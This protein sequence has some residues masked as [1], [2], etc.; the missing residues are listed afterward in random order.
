MYFV[1]PVSIPVHLLWWLN[2][3]YFSSMT[4]WQTHKFLAHQFSG[5]LHSFQ[6]NLQFFT[7]L[8]N[9]QKPAIWDCSRQFSFSLFMRVICTTS[10]L[11]E[12]L[13]NFFWIFLELFSKAMVFYQSFGGHFLSTHIGFK[14]TTVI[15]KT[16]LNKS[17]IITESRQGLY[18][19]RS[20]I[21]YGHKQC[22]KVTLGKSVILE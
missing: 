2:S 19:K 3:N 1:L 20:F 16:S 14:D 15:T 6:M 7:T 21:L 18:N 17:L 9:K 5:C 12:M 22:S 10:A 11:F 13:S 4:T 8:K